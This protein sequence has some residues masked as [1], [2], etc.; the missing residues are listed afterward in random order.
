MDLTSYYIKMREQ[1]AIIP[2][3]YPVVVSHATSD[4][5]VKG[6]MTEVTKRIAARLIVEGFA[7]LADAVETNQFHTLKQEAKAAVENAAK[8]MAL[9]ATQIA[10]SKL[11]HAAAPLTPPAPIPAP[12]QTPVLTEETPKE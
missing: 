9:E 1:Q 5:G 2:D 11:M 4:G 7:R 8:G 6:R 10:I 3:E 12:I